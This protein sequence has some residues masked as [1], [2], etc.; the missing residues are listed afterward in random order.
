MR[1]QEDRRVPEKRLTP[2]A[3]KLVALSA[4][5]LALLR[6]ASF[7]PEFPPALFALVMLDLLLVQCVILGHP[8]RVFHYTFLVAGLV[9]SFTL[10]GGHLATGR[11]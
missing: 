2:V 7:L 6:A 5:N 10:H 1:G 3:M 4:L 9:A 8:L 11:E